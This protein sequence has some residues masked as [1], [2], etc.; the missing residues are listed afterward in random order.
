MK[1]QEM[2]LKNEL[3]QFP[4]NFTEANAQGSPRFG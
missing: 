4:T 1:L 3:V 2:I